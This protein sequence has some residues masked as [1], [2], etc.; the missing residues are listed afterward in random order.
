M[1]VLITDFGSAKI[2]DEPTNPGK[3]FNY[4]IIV[5]IS[6]YNNANTTTGKDRGNFY[7]KNEEISQ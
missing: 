1:H 3:Y 5:I 6:T 4:H 2:L 7:R